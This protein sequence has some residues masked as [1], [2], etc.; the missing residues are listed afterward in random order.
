LRACRAR[1]PKEK[2]ISIPGKKA[3][4]LEKREGDVCPAKW[5][6]FA[7][8]L[9]RLVLNGSGR[10]GLIKGQVAAGGARQRRLGEELK[11]RK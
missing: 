1:K 5:F 7:G 4:T 9:R 2:R 6:V 3:R 8:T 11:E 10:D